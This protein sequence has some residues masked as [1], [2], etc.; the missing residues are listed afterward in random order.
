MDILSVPDPDP[1][2]SLTVVFTDCMDFDTVF[3]S[4]VADSGL[5]AF[6]RAR[7]KLPTLSIK[8]RF[9]GPWLCVDLA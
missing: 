6:G 7:F 9:V 5:V 8:E 2:P 3:A 1:I 4:S